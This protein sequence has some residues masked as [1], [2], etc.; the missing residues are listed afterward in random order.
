M[1][2]L[3]FTRD[4]IICPK[5]F[6]KSGKKVLLIAKEGHEFNK[7]NAESN[8]SDGVNFWVADGYCERIHGREVSSFLNCLAAYCNAVVDEDFDF[9][10]NK[11]L[12]RSV[13]RN[14]AFMNINKRGGFE[15][16]PD[17]VLI[18]YAERFE[19]FINREIAIIGP[20]YIIF[21][22]SGLYDL[23]RDKISIPT[24]SKVYEA[25]HPRAWGGYATKLR[26][27]EPKN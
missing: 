26:N 27:M 18:G 9:N 15:K 19:A 4:G 25:C 12:D 3:S 23:I 1:N 7:P 10:R 5:E 17:S 2:K 20:D 13:L 22:G 6:G 16:C 11:H 14:A 21:C 24:K 8:C